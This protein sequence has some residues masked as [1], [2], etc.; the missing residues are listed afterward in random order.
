MLKLS[1]AVEFKIKFA[2]FGPWKAESFGVTRNGIPRI[3]LN[4]L[5]NSD[6][7]FADLANI[8][9]SFTKSLALNWANTLRIASR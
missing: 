2:K 5:T 8:E 6:D 4:T 7:I 3:F 1:T 9:Q